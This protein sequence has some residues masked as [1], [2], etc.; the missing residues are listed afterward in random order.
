MFC[1]AADQEIRDAGWVK[2]EEFNKLLKLYEEAKE[3][4]NQHPPV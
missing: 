1:P 3:Q 4:L 2:Q